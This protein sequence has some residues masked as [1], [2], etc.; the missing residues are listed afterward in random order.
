MANEPDLRQGATDAET[1]GWVTYLQQ[2]LADLYTGAI[3]GI[4][5]P[6]TDGAVRAYQQQHQLLV[7]GWVGPITW[8][9]LTGEQGGDSGGGGGGEDAVPQDLVTAG[10][11]AN[12]SE[13]T[14]EQKAEFFKYSPKEGSPQGEQDEVAVAEISTDSDDGSQTA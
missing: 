2:L 1:N 4:F 5:G 7:D 10:A 3:D 6:I 11:P 14:E 9:S 13:W 8:G 12:F